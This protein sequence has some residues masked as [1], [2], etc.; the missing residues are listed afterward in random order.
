LILSWVMGNAFARAVGERHPST[1]EAIA[2]TYYLWDLLKV[3]RWS[4]FGCSLGVFLRRGW[5]WA[6]VL[7]LRD[8]IR[9]EVYYN[10]FTLRLMVISVARRVNS[11][12]I[13]FPLLRVI[14]PLYCTSAS[15]NPFHKRRQSKIHCKST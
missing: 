2:G 6:T 7:K 11:R 4:V 3:L 1:V 14:I 13:H 9:G 5:N 8:H 12:G 15:K 10:R